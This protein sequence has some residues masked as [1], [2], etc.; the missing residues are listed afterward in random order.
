M[1]EAGGS[2][3]D[4][5]ALVERIDSQGL[6]RHI[7]GLPE[8][9]AEAWEQATAIGLPERYRD[10]REIVVLGMGGSAIAGDIVGSLAAIS[11][12]KPVS[13][14]RGYDLPPYIGDST[15]VVACSHSGNTEE[16]L[17][18]VDKALEAGARLAVVTTGGRLREL[19]QERALPAFVYL[20]D[21]GPRSAI[22]HQLMRLLAVAQQAGALDDQG[23]ALTE[24]VALMRDQR[25][26]LG[27]AS[28]AERNP[29]KQLAARLH[30]RLP[31]IIGAGVLAEAAHRWR[32][33]LNENSK[34]WALNDALPELGHNSIVGFGLPREALD[35]LHVVFLA[36]PALHPRVLIQYDVIAD[37]LTRAGVSHERLEARGS[38]PLAQALTAIYFG[39][40][41]SYY[42][43]LLYGVDPSPV[44]AIGRLKARLAAS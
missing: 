34:S 19:A 25:D 21:G 12:R 11:G 42:L 7:E 29:A 23:A 17:S 14:V 41:V 32:T 13:V 33:Q 6:L 16:T 22:G 39:D 1:L 40:L 35:L 38:S 18:A 3:L 44:D 27:F 43:A 15:L 2:A 37:E 24:T 36:H 31:V 20:F 28:A 5:R 4:D 8:Q 26:Q 9:C 30:G 10:A